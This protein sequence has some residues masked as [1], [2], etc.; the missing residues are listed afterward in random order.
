M[1]YTHMIGLAYVF[2]VFPDTP[3]MGLH[4]EKVAP[5]LLGVCIGL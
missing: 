1:E 2:A 3:L 4:H 5:T